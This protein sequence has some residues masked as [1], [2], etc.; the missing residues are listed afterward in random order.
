MMKLTVAA[1]QTI[2][3]KIRTRRTKYPM[4]NR[5]L[6]P[7]RW[8]RQLYPA[9]GKLSIDRSPPL[10]VRRVDPEPRCAAGANVQDAVMLRSIEVHAVALREAVADVV[11]LVLHLAGEHD[12]ELVARVHRKLGAVARVQAVHEGVH[13][14]AQRGRELFL[15]QALIQVGKAPP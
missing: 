9:L 15:H 5:N 4:G 12:R 10:R 1:A 8:R 11:D 6:R 7:P 2:R 13:S 14:A 3:R